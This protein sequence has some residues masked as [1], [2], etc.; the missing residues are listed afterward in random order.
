M[1]LRLLV[2]YPLLYAAAFTAVAAWLVDSG[3]ELV[4][5]VTAQRI[6][7]RI[8]A[9]WGCFA[10]VSAFEPGDRLRRAWLCLGS[11][12]ILILARDI[13]RLFPP[14]APGAGPEAQAIL[15][16]LGVTSNLALLAGILMLARAWRLVA[17]E[18]PG[19]RPGVA[20]IAL[21]TAAVALLVAGPGALREA[22]AVAEGNW[23][24]LIFLVSALVDIVTLC[25]IMPLLL[26]AVALRGGSFS[27]PWG[28]LAAS[29]ISW[30]LYDVA[31]SLLMTRLG[32]AVVPPH[33]VFPL[34]EVFRGLAGNLL[35]A[36]GLAQYLVVLQ[37]RR[38]ARGG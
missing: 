35:C 5:F 32:P 14:Y 31:A 3:G 27:W 26:T 13:L 20:A 17:I 7:T 16:G 19:G 34:H 28:L 21:V 29:Q 8:L 24:S 23:S 30:L 37:V 10:A 1:R 36:A 12:T 15:T 18:L 33:E 6:L 25:L 22:Q 38:M 9:A 4:P 2:L 11:G